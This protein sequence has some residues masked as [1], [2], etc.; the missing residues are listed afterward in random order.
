[1]NRKRILI[2]GGGTAGITAAAQLKRSGRDLDIRIISPE[3]I[4]YY[5][6]LWT[7]V[8]G[9]LATLDE[10]VRPEAPLIP[11]GVEWIRDAVAEF[12]PANN[13]VRT[14]SGRSYDYDGLIVAV[15][16]RMALEEVP[17]LQEALDHDPRVWTNY[18]ARYVTKGPAAVQGF[19]G[20]NALFT[21]PASPLKCGGAPVKILWIVEESLRKFGT[22]ASADVSY[23][24]PDQEIFGVPEYAATLARLAKERD[25]HLVPRQS[26]I[27]IRHQDGI[28]IFEHLDTHEEVEVPY[29][30][31]HVTPPQRAPEVVAH[32]PLASPDYERPLEKRSAGAQRRG[33]AQRGPG[34]FVD[35]DKH[36]TQHVRFPNVFSVG[37]ASTLP[38]AK[39]G[40]GVRKQ[41]PVMVANLLSSL[42]GKPLEKSYDGYTS[43]PLVVGHNRVVLAEFGYDGKL[44]ESF[45]ID[46]SKPRWSMWL[47]KRYLLPQLYW[48]GMLKGRA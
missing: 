32:S 40:A 6:P 14:A 2:I 8:G 25:V 11:P 3:D 43:C 17:G 4:H 23:Y 21:K 36:T 48:K 16:L 18:M 35:V 46:Q 39:T 9:G 27:E 34:G 44:M 24:T 45:P 7:L 5:Q 31:L 37:D 19:R 15:G 20:G 13:A 42:D 1:M 10:T 26:L 47:L 29:G 33:C 28:A 22:R 41:V 12:D 30:L 38:T